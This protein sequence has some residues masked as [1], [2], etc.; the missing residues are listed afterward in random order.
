MFH[1]ELLSEFG[2]QPICTKPT[3]ILVSET[4]TAKEVISAQ[5]VAHFRGAH[6]DIEKALETR[7]GLASLL[8]DG[9]CGL[10][11]TESEA[12]DFAI[13]AFQRNEFFFFWNDKQVLDLE[14]LLLVAE[15]NEA[16]FI[17]IFPLQGG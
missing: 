14:D 6:K 10:P 5:A 9:Y 2:E 3:L 8:L 17:K 4:V 1:Y 7:Q 11:V 13:E 16:K 12:R 15:A